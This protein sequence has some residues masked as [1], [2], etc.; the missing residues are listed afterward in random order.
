LELRKCDSLPNCT[1]DLLNS[2]LDT[3]SNIIQANMTPLSYILG[4]YEPAYPVIQNQTVYVNQ[5]QVVYQSTSGGTTT[6]I[7]PYPFPVEVIKNITV[8]VPR[9]IATK[10]LNPLLPLE[11]YK[12]DTQ[13][14]FIE[15]HNSEN[16]TFENISIS[17]G[18]TDLSVEVKPNTNKVGRLA[19][20]ETLVIPTKVTTKN[21]RLGNLSVSISAASASPI[22]TDNTSLDIA[23][24]AYKKSDIF[25]TQKFIEFA[26]GLLKD[27]A[28]CV[29]LT[30][31][32]NAAKA[33]F[34]SG[35]IGKARSNTQ[36]IIDSCRSVISLR[37]EQAVANIPPSSIG[38]FL[39]RLPTT[40][41]AAIIFVSGSILALALLFVLSVR[42]KVVPSAIK[43][44]LPAFIRRL[45]GDRKR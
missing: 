2:T 15:L 41:E 42:S 10:L 7:R 4:L 17:I 31:G 21:T 45:L 24:V 33:D 19:P 18:S 25:E 43:N 39:Q 38:G 8:E 20:G 26:D 1:L 27:N 16:V 44:R 3:T 29:E 35:N 5:T 14:I 30:A 6:E 13:N 11:L 37:V 32:L 9:Y 40:T 36:A 12:N 34:D 22:I 23:V 28:E